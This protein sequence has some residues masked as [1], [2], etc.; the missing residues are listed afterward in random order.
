MKAILIAALAGACLLAAGC[1]SQ[2]TEKT[3]QEAAK[4]TEQ[5]K[6]GSKVAA[7]ELKK[8]AKEAVRQTKAAAA[9][10]KQ[11]LQADDPPVN[12]NKANKAQLQTLPGIDEETAG[13]I[14]A[15]RPYHTRD[16]IGTR[17]VVSPDQF[18]AIKDKISVK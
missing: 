5:I 15:G 14:V 2:D 1:S 11:G 10:V 3:K 9:G 8:D 13:R 17:G 7:V 6:E 12:V 4:A 16:E 18:T